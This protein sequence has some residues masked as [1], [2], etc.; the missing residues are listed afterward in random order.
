MFPLL[1]LICIH[2]IKSDNMNMLQKH[3]DIQKYNLRYNNIFFLILKYIQG[4]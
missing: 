1:F 3:L 4:E 2:Y